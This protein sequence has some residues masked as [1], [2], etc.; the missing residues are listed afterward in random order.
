MSN[1]NLPDLQPLT[2]TREQAAAMLG[3]APKTL[4]NL[5]SPGRGAVVTRLPGVKRT[6]YRVSDLETYVNR[7]RGGAA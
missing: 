7:H 6:L 4:A 5:A 3:I 2:V 1:S